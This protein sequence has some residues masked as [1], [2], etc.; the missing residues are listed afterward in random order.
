MARL[1]NINRNVSKGEN[2]I[3]FASILR[4]W[5]LVTPLALVAMAALIVAGAALAPASA[6]GGP[7]LGGS[8]AGALFRI[9]TPFSIT[10]AKAAACWT[11]KVSTH[12]STQVGPITGGEPIILAA[13]IEQSG[14]DFQVKAVEFGKCGAVV[15][16]NSHRKTSTS[17]ATDFGFANNGDRSNGITVFDISAPP[18]STELINLPASNALNGQAELSTTSQ[19]H[20]VKGAAVLST[21]VVENS[22]DG[23]IFVLSNGGNTPVSN[24]LN[25]GSN[26][27][28]S[29]LSGT[30]Y[31]AVL[32]EVD[33]TSNSITTIGLHVFGNGVDVR[34][35]QSTASAHC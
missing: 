14:N 34:L 5:R 22:A 24:D 3:M 23:T 20:C 2:R 4:R 30:G 18:F 31:T 10:A 13:I 29:G 6:S 8:A 32:D 26:Q 17:T 19:A 16:T 35:A 28:L 12:H 27:V 7:K 1:F 33:T 9:A 25:L 21:S 15:K 11:G